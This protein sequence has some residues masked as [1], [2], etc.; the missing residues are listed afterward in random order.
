M[1][2]DDADLEEEAKAREREGRGAEDRGEREREE[3]SIMWH[4]E[5]RAGNGVM[6]VSFFELPESNSWPLFFS[7]FYWL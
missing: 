6:S 2:D 3:R 5:R 7:S 1:D 4:K